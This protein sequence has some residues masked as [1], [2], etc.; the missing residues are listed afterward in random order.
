MYS[1]HTETDRDRERER[2]RDRET[3][4]QTDRFL[5]A[6]WVDD[7]D[8]QLSSACTERFHSERSLDA[9]YATYRL[10]TCTQ[11]LPT[12]VLLYTALFHHYVNSALHPSGVA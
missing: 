8:S 9:H 1:R 3:E 6:E 10:Y 4:K 2:E 7:V 12:T 5:Y 11:Q